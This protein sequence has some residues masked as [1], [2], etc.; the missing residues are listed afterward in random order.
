MTRKGVKWKSYYTYKRK[1]VTADKNLE[2]LRS[3]VNMN[4]WQ[5]VCLSIINDAIHTNKRGRQ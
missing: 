3:D 1:Q 2:I 5:Y 4:F